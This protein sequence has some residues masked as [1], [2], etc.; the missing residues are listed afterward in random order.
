MGRKVYII[1]FSIIDTV[2][3]YALESG[4][5]T[6]LTPLMQRCITQL[7]EVTAE[8]KEQFAGDILK[9][10]EYQAYRRK[11]TA[12]R[13]LE[14]VGMVALAAAGARQLYSLVNPYIQDYIDLNYPTLAQNL[15]KLSTIVSENPY[16]Y[17]AAALS[18]GVALAAF[19]AH[20]ELSKPAV[21]DD[22]TLAI[23]QDFDVSRN[24][25]LDVEE[26]YFGILYDTSL[27][28]AGDLTILTDLLPKL[29]NGLAELN[30]QI[31]SQ[32]QDWQEDLK[33]KYATLVSKS[34]KLHALVEKIKSLSD[35]R[36][37]AQESKAKAVEQTKSLETGPVEKRKRRRFPT[38]L[39]ALGLG[40]AS[41]STGNSTRTQGV[42]SYAPDQV[43]LLALYAG[44]AI[45]GSHYLEENISADYHKQL[46]SG[47][48]KSEEAK[49]AKLAADMQEF[50]FEQLAQHQEKVREIGQDIDLTGLNAKQIL[51]KIMRGNARKFGPSDDVSAL[52]EHH[53]EMIQAACQ[54]I[55]LR[56][57]QRSNG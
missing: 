6:Q 31:D 40:V 39:T 8:R 27:V 12:A 23:I 28:Q 22:T 25:R 16:I 35:A 52:I 29:K 7:G 54:L 48:R 4:T 43:S 41:R 13:S 55:K 32:A 51:A 45:C 53:D 47:L 15:D 33:E 44:A 30:T 57:E 56:L 2:S 20:Y 14:T 1:L 19:R 49:F 10:P 3:L 21:P 34:Q 5:P 26:K 38:L 46:R 37:G 17:P 42:G 9:S 36:F 50:T 11:K 18:A 24:G